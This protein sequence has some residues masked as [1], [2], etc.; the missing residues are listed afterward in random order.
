MT[1][2]ADTMTPAERMAAVRDPRRRPDRVPF[3]PRVYGYPMAL[4]GWAVADAYRDADRS[5]HGRL[6]ARESIGYDDAFALY[7]YAS[8]GAWELGGEVKM[9]RGEYATAPSITRHP[10]ESEDDLDRLR[11]PEDV[12]SAGSVPIMLRFARLQQ[13]HGLPVSL[14]LG[15]PFTD[16]ANVVEP[17][18]FLKWLVKRP[19]LAHRCLRVMTDFFL[20][21]AAEWVRLFPGCVVVGF[22]GTPGE[23]NTMI[24]EAHFRD[25]A[26]PYMR[27]VHE[28]ALHLGVSYFHTHLCGEQAAN[29]PFFADVPFGLPGSPGLVSVGHE[30]PL[31]RALEVVGSEA[32]VMGNVD[33]QEIR[34]ATAERVFHLAREAVLEG[35]DAPVGYVLMSGCEVPVDTPVENLEAMLRAVREHGWYG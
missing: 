32:V 26:L 1:V 8:M 6:R 13:A 20:A 11:V 35:K 18:L 4:S 34:F 14:D 21:L 12:L 10:V 31:A 19:A 28:K 33:P 7:A 30:T 29:L 15:T 27:E 23:A 24:S 16:A 17:S 5:F 3:V 22:D 2:R 9:P 25:Y